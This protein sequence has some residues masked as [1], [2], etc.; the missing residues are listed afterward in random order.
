MKRLQWLS[1]L[2]CISLIIIIGFQVYWLKEN[3]NREYRTLQIKTGVSFQ[4][5]I[6]QLQMV[7]LKLPECSSS[8]TGLGTISTTLVCAIVCNDKSNEARIMG[9]FIFNF[10]I[11]F[12]FNG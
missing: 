11:F 2:M 3:Y 9:F 7:K 1:V 5:T 4:E 8:D 10:L 12:I 6:R